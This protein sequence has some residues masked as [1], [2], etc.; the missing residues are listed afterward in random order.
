MYTTCLFCNADLGA[1]TALP[2]FPVG[3]RLAFDTARGRLWVICAVCDRWNLSPL[4]ERW[5]AIEECERRFRGTK[6]RYS[7][8][9]VGLGYLPEGLALIRIGPALKPE[10]AAWRYGRLLGRWLP[11]ARRD[12]L[13]RL[14]KKWAGRGEAAVDYT[15]RRVFGVHLGYDLATWL[16]VHGQADR[17][18]VVTRGDDGNMA[19]IRA[20]DLDQTEL[21]RPDPRAPWQLQVRQQHGVTTLSGDAGLHVA[22]KLLSV[23]NGGGATEAEV[24]FAV[25]KLEDA[26]NPASY[27][28]RVAA[29]AMRCSWGRFPDA[30]PSAEPMPEPPASEAERLALSITKRS[31]WGRGGIGSEPRTPLP[32]LPLVDRL[33]LEM[34]AN[35]DVERRALEGELALLESAW[36]GAE[37]IAAIA[38]RLF[39]DRSRAEPLPVTT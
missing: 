17:V 36:R 19:V 32:R 8:D 35:E 33:A 31:F 24:R 18:L 26:G 11:A 27:F 28:A 29:I 4:D 1:N 12:P 20:R 34:A 23:L 38:D 5:E 25:A 3:S 22:G 2:T 7:T 39:L 9:N 30:L 37:A 14:A 13:L 6:L 15:F 21:I 16:R 10:I